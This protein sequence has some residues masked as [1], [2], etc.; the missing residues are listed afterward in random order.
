MP[1]T[2]F[3]CD[4]LNLLQAA[5]C[6]VLQQEVAQGHHSSKQ[7]SLAGSYSEKKESFFGFSFREFKA[8]HCKLFRI[9]RRGDLSR[10]FN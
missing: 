8:L 4:K 2:Y 9:A 6:Y 7:V 3:W 5:L 1:V 10:N